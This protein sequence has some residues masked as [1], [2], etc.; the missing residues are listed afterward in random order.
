MKLLTLDI[1][2]LFPKQGN[3]RYEELH[4]V[5][6]NPVGETSGNLREVAGPSAGALRR[7][8]ERWPI[9]LVVLQNIRPSGA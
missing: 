3:T 1:D 6:Y 5:G 7:P 9:S 2:K 4:C 8:K